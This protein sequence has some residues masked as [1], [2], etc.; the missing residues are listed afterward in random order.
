M[1]ER[2]NE[3][4][5]E[6]GWKGSRSGE[7]DGKVGDRYPRRG[8]PMLKMKEGRK[9]ERRKY[10]RSRRTRNYHEVSHFLLF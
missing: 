9:N 3:G 6:T 10:K 4:G 8:T 2:G 5:R 7:Q 1:K